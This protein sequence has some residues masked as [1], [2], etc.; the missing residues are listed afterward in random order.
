VAPPQVTVAA[1]TGY[2]TATGA[3]YGAR[4]RSS[5]LLTGPADASARWHPIGTPCSRWTLSLAATPG[6]AL[7][8][9]CAGQPSAGEQLKRAYL[10]PG[11][12]SAWQR[13]A[14]PPAS[15]Y[16]YTV[17]ITPAGTILLSG[18]R[19]DVYVSWDGGQTWHGTAGT[20]PSMLRA[21]QGGETL[22]AAMTT[23]TQG[24]TIEP[25]SGGGSIWFTY[26]DAHT[27]HLVIM[28]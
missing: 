11:D 26:D 7:A 3:N 19:S 20:S 21:Y 2:V 15:G 13:L 17:S 27:W 16:L 23:G 28:H 4:L 22:S 24:F 10:S 9:G 6:L 8:L 14:G 18:G 1:G 12:G 5:P 25:G